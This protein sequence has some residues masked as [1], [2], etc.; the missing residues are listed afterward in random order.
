MESY[1]SV[2]TVLVV[3]RSDKHRYLDWCEAIEGM[4]QSQEKTRKFSQARLAIAAT[5]HPDSLER[6]QNALHLRLRILQFYMRT[7]HRHRTTE[8]SSVP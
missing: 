1:G 6:A 3:A 8:L 4:G 7:T 2:A 5:R